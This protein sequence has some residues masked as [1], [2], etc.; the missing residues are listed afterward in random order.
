MT[1]ANSENVA[2]RVAARIDLVRISDLLSP[3]HVRVP[4]ESVDKQGVLA[5]L[6]GLV[7]EAAGLEEERASILEAVQQRESVLSTGIGQ[8]VALPHAKFNGLKD[9]AVA[10]GVSRAPI[11]YGSLDGGPAQLFFM[12]I[13]PDSKAVAHVRVLSRISR[14]LR[15]RSVRERLLASTDALHFLETIEEAERAA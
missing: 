6:V 1:R 5:E 2:P 3:D 14:L 13:G 11:D 7:I 10:A 4:L 8:G 12:I 9:I 15:N